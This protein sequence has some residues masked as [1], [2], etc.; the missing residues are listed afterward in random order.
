MISLRGRIPIPVAD[1]IANRLARVMRPPARPPRL[2][3]W[4]RGLTFR[5]GRRT[6]PF[7]P[8]DHP[9]QYFAL[10][11]F[12]R[13]LDR[14]W[15]YRQFITIKPTQD[16]GTM[17]CQSILQL[18]VLGI[19]GD[20]VVA[21]LPDMN[22]AGKQWRE[23][24]RPLVI[25]S[26]LDPWLPTEGPGSE[27][28][29]TPISVQINGATLT[30][31]GGGASNEA[32]QAMVS[33]R[34]L[35][36]DELDSIDPWNAELMKGRLDSYPDDSLISDTSTIKHD[37]LEASQIL[38]SFEV[39]TRGVME[40]ACP[41][42][43]TFIDWRWKM[44]DV[45]L[46]SEI[47]AQASPHLVCPSCQ[48]RHDEV[49]RRAMVRRLENARLAG[50][51]WH[52]THDGQIHGTVPDTLTWGHLWRAL[53]SPLQSMP[54]L[55]A[56]YWAAQHALKT[57]G[58]HHPLRRFTRDRD[59]AI[60][61]G[62][63]QAEDLALARITRALL[64]ARANHTTDWRLAH[65]ERAE[66]GD[67]LHIASDAQ[68]AEFLTIAVDVQKGGERSP[69]RAYFLIQGMDSAQRTWDC[70]WGHVIF[71]AAGRQA[72][73]PEIM[74]G[75][76]RLTAQADA[77]AAR[78]DRPLVRRGIDVGDQQDTLRRWLLRRPAWWAVKG[79]S[80][81]VKV[82]KVVTDDLAGWIQGTEQTDRDGRFR[83]WLI[84]TDE[85][86]RFAQNAFLL[87]AGAPGAAHLPAGIDG[88]SAIVRHY[89][90]TAEIPD[91]KGGTIWSDREKHREHHP[92]WQTRHDFLDCR[93]YAVALGRQYLQTL[94]RP[95]PR[96]VDANAWFGTK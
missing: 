62:D 2:L 36:R 64:V 56:K 10:L 13:I 6:F 59:C 41:R 89:C 63:D 52:L 96:K 78:F 57:R 51:G 18:Y 20:P 12:D 22:L 24:T 32:G 37:R 1:R 38:S 72:S 82:G 39:S 68:A 81:E 25:D 21:G 69:P 71:C 49:A 35:A 83:L 16:G 14:Q 5:K 79:A 85:P 28:N 4:A 30:Y 23:K 29:S 92:E 11:A 42:C 66:D 9:A 44:V 7:R 34:V 77:I 93:R 61:V 45:D 91:G 46:T 48:A 50:P 27:G 73:E 75:L 84:A 58:D 47:T 65:N 17:V 95:A 15:R 54:D 86:Q 76:D 88:T 67:S 55:A 43:R 53:H 94:T 33:A 8:D 60:Y 90:A 70:A 3:P 26:A 40:Y 19:L 31:M 87:P 74:L 80:R